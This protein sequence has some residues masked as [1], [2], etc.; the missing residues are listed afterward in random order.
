MHGHAQSLELVSSGR[1]MQHFSQFGDLEI[2]IQERQVK[3]INA[4]RSF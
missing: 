3:Q 2:F 1:I 4:L